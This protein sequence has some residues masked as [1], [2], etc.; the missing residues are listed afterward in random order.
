MSECAV[1]YIISGL[2]VLM[3]VL[4]LPPVFRRTIG[5]LIDRWDGR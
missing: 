1:T 5:P 2:A 4:S 3:S